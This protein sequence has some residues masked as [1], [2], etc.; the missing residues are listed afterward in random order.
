[1]QRRLQAPPALPSQEM[2]E[3][4]PAALAERAGD[5][6]PD[7]LTAEAPLCDRSAT[8]RGLQGRGLSV[9]PHFLAARA[10]LAGSLAL[11]PSPP[12]FL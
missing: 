10:P 2:T 7:F 9:D 12:V 4:N 3:A 5:T 1:M 6:A 8:Y 11:N